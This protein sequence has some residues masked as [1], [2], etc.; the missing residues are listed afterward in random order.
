MWHCADL[1]VF[2]KHAYEVLS[3]C[4]VSVLF[5][6]LL[7]VSVVCGQL[8][9]DRQSHPRPGEKLNADNA[10]MLKPHLMTNLTN[11]IQ[12]QYNH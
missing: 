11:S 4:Q 8:Y 7:R 12:M 9:V 6:S 3:S 5:C 2:V 10:E 1:D